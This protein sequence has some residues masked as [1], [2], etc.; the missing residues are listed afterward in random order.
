MNQ[1][2]WHR[3]QKSVA[4]G[5]L[6]NS[7]HPKM[8]IQGAYPTHVSHGIGSYLYDTD[9]KKY[10]DYICGLGVNLFGYGNDKINKELMK[11]IYGGF[12]HS[13][14]TKHEVEAAE[15]LKEIFCFVDRWKFLKT[16][17]DACSAAIK[18]A[19][20]R[21]GVRDGNEKM[22]EMWYREIFKRISSSV[23]K[24]W[25]TQRNLQNM[26]KGTSQETGNFGNKED[27]TKEICKNP[28][29]K[30]DRSQI[31]SDSAP[32]IASSW[33]KP[34]LLQVENGIKEWD[35]NKETLR[36]M[37]RNKLASSSSR[38]FEAVGRDV[39]LSLSSCSGTRFLILSD[40]YHGHHDS[41][42]GLTSPHCGVPL[43]AG[44]LPLTGNED[45]IA[46]AAAVII[47]P[48]MT[49]HSP[50]RIDY[51]NQLRKKCT[52]MG[53]MLIFDEVITGFRFKKFGVC[54]YTGVIPDL[55]V[56]GKA[57]ANG[58]PLSAVG[59]KAAVMDD[60]GYFISSTYAG[61]V[62]S[63]AACRKVCELLL[64]DSDYNI[65][66]LWKCG[67][68]F[69]DAFNQQ[70]TD[71]KL[72]GYPSRGVFTGSDENIAIFMQEMAKSEILFCK[73]FFYNFGHISHNHDILAI[74]L[75]IKERIADG[76]AKLRFPMPQS[77][78]SMGVRNGNSK[79]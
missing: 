46:I 13:L 1:Q 16:G 61:E 57:M 68:D 73:S 45:L 25:E 64:K 7:K 53:A 24:N 75:E 70:P 38:L 62:F 17:S 37:W 36:E 76:S 60:P 42:V 20:N 33:E 72:A 3:A 31:Q 65:D 6:T 51:L 27:S 79:G 56:I 50:E 59:G 15:A 74:A 66:Y 69:I 2:W 5:A 77:P 48:V 9:G 58:L 43:Q 32:E 63:L 8:L 26:C 12:S 28:K 49:D 4:Q 21:W 39:A 78:F 44:I 23:E 40:G 47:E 30:S 55:I 18:I 22:H 41:F 52:D 11:H 34:S 67:Q 19:R 14:P 35:F 54:N 71:V 29:G 10:L